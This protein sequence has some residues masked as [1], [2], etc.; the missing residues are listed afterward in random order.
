MIIL[1]HIRLLAFLSVILCSTSAFAQRGDRRGHVMK[2]VW[3]DMEVPPSPVYRPEEVLKT[4]Q[5]AEGFKLELAAS[6]PLIVDPVQIVWDPDGRMWA[7]EMRGYMPNVDGKGEDVRNGQIVVLE[8]LDDD[9]KYDK[10]TVFLGELQMP[11]AVALVDGGVFV[12]EPPFLWYCKDND[13]DLKCDEKIAVHKRYA[14]QGPVEHT[15]NGL[16]WALDNW[17][18]NAKS[19]KRFKFKNGKIIEEHTNSHGQWGITQDN[20]GRLYH[21]GNSSYLHA[22]LF[23][24]YYFKRNPALSRPSGFGHRVVGDQRT[25]TARV[26]PGINRGYMRGMLTKEGKLSRTTGCSGQGI[27][28]GDALPEDC[29]GNGFV[30][31]PCGNLVERFIIKENGVELKGTRA[32]P[33]KAFLASTDERF[34]P[35]NCETGPDGGLYIVDLYRGIL[36]HKVYV[37]TFLRKQI[38]ERGLDKPVGLGRIYRVTHESGKRGPKPNLSKAAAKELVPHLAHPNGWWRDTVQRMLI[39]RN[40]K[41]VVPDIRKIAMDDSNHL[42]QIH[43]LW[44]LE[45]LDAVDAETVVAGLEAE[46]HQTKIAALRVGEELIGTKSEKGFFAGMVDLLEDESRAVHVQLM[47]TLG[48]AKK[49]EKVL[50]LMQKHAAIHGGD[51]YVRQAYLSGV[52]GVELNQAAMLVNDPANKTNK[53]LGGLLKDLA[54]SASRSRK[55]KAVGRTLG[56]IAATSDEMDW[57]QHAILSGIEGNLKKAVHFKKKP[58]AW[59]VLMASENQS[60]VKRLKSWEGKRLVWGNKFP[61][62]GQDEGPKLSDEERKLALAGKKFFFQTCAQCHQFDGEGQPGVAPPLVES[63]WVL[64]NEKRLTRIVLQGVMGKIR[65]R[66]EEWDLVMPGHFA[67]PDLTDETLAGLLTFLRTNGN[68]EHEAKPVSIETVGA[69]RKEV[70]GQQEPWTVEE[71]MKVK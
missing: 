1:R 35:V 67:N 61:K 39:E 60:L 7:A 11:R 14:R 5:I 34:R 45:G 42:G 68:W 30:P 53:K 20:Y 2:E 19:N 63:E 56:L 12:A 23:P 28:R 31:E 9:G 32:Y 15:D 24:Y 64:G 26:N 21:N 43:A 70:K 57:A 8:D 37:T 59:E 48:Q 16:V 25:F 58:A 33:K 40:D 66:G 52:Y 10:S 27:F 49:N 71:L 29:I 17:M 55:P 13:G 44:T 41:S 62:P 3:K 69:V 18:Y 36:Q 6:E 22:D 50:K 51:K 65:V 54:S 46:H 4:F 47:F 38:L